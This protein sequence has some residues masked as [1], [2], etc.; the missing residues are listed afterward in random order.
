[1]A[2]SLKAHELDEMNDTDLE[3]RLPPVSPVT[4]PPV[5]VPVMSTAAPSGR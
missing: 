4:M 2:G 5:T 3:S 1:M